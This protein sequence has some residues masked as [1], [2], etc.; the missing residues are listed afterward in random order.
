MGA[1]SLETARAHSP[2]GGNMG[3][4]WLTAAAA[5]VIILLAASP[6]VDH[7]GAS[8]ASTGVAKAQQTSG[9][10]TQAESGE[11]SVPVTESRPA[12]TGTDKTGTDW[13]SARSASEEAVG[14]I[15]AATKRTAKEA[16]DATKST[17]QQAW[18]ATKEGAGKAAKATTDTT[19][20][21]W[22]ATKEG[23]SKA[24]SAT[25]ETAS[26]AWDATKEAS[27][28]VWSSI[29]RTAGEISGSSG[30]QGA[31]TADGADGNAGGKAPQ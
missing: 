30:N 15:G 17:S 14:A 5:V 31:T 21:A 7:T 20:K 13:E 3:Y 22:E 4:Q 25:T 19:S 28:S 10:T 27:Q 18:D 11:S 8:G 26:K 2:Y 24:A 23:A 29:K 9:K 12:S 1:T 6:Y 16:W